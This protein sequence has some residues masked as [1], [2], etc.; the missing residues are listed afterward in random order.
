MR[1]GFEFALSKS[2]ST[3]ATQLICVTLLGTLN[4]FFGQF[5][6][7]FII[8]AVFWWLFTVSVDFHNFLWIASAKEGEFHYSLLRNLSVIHRFTRP[9]FKQ[10]RQSLS[11]SFLFHFCCKF[12]TVWLEL[13]CYT[14]KV[15]K[16]RMLLYLETTLTT[17]AA[18][19][20]KVRWLNGS[21]KSSEVCC[22]CATSAYQSMRKIGI[23]I[24]VC[25]Q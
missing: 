24:T 20:S 12:V 1:S 2:A 8:C 23:K 11:V 14:D 18:K 13:S 19:T 7:V 21:N 4:Q 3:D 6:A 17:L 9:S 15:K 22:V 10:T 5:W 25:S 16:A